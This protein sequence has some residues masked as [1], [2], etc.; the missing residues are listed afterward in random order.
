MRELLRFVIQ[1]RR[2]AA[3]PAVMPVSAEVERPDA[4]PIATG[5]E[6][7]SPAPFAD[8]PNTLGTPRLVRAELRTH[9]HPEAILKKRPARTPGS[10]G[11]IVAT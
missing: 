8:G 4:R 6:L 9:L 5:S 1:Q 10:T 11:R 2:P 7:H 3:A